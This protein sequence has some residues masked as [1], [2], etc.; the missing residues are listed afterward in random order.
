MNHSAK[1]IVLGLI[2]LCAVLLRFNKLDSIP[3]GLQQDETSIGYNAFSILTTGRDE[4]GVRMPLY[5]KAFGEYKLPGY[6]YG[7]VVPI[8]VFGLTPLG[9]RFF[10]ALTGSLTVLVI[11]WF[12]HVLFY[13]VTKG[14]GDKE[15]T[16][17][18]IAAAS[19][20]AINPWHLHF[21][22]GAFEVTP[23][24]FF[25]G[26]GVTLFLHG[27]NKEK[28]LHIL[29]GIVTLLFS[30]YIYNIT[31]ILA[32]LLLLYLFI[33][34]FKHLKI[35]GTL[36]PALIVSIITLIPFIISLQTSGGVNAARGTLINSSAVVQA[37]LLEYRSYMITLPG[38]VGKIFFNSRNLTLW[39][40]IQNIARYMSVDF[41][42]LSGSSHGNHGIGTTGQFYL[43][44]LPLIITGII[45]LLL[46]KKRQAGFLLM[47]IASTI[48]I[49]ALTREAPQ[50]TRSFFLIVPFI[51][52]SAVGL[53]WVARRVGSLTTSIKLVVT[54]A[55][56]LFVFFNI[57]WYISSYYIRFPVAYA[58]AWRSADSQVSEFIKENQQKYDIILIDLDSGFLY[59]SYLFYTAF[60]PDEFQKTVRRAPD[61]NEGFSNVESFGNVRIRQI[62]W[63]R[64]M[65]TPRTLIITTENRK[66]ADVPP[67]KTFYYPRRP[68]VFAVKQEIVQ[69]P[70]EEIAYVAVI[71]P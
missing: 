16:A 33:A 65:Q 38:I 70:V 44:D 46:T 45:A 20:L 19:L 67:F 5:F 24:L 14:S 10:S 52:C 3:N 39:Y 17:T 35:H 48:V 66:P 4:Y 2:L 32:P 1:Y 61:D 47:W 55:M 12:V 27:I 60:S 15:I 63:S 6:I 62:D 69:Y 22:R 50:A 71:T 30:V 18:A 40:F 9:V 57:V 68:V 25:L 7:S 13:H 8:K 36:I 56:L 54:G 11:Y 43:F 29:L 28:T 31:R 53:V 41:F 49:A 51:V 23:S 42:F 64:D 26:L 58:K 34:Q 37:S 59:S 21:S